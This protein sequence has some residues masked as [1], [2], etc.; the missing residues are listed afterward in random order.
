MKRV[1]VTLASTLLCLGT[2]SAIADS[3][4]E[5]QDGPGWTP[6]ETW[7]CDFRDGKTLEDLQEVTAEWNEFLDDE[8]VDYYFGAIVMPNY[9][10]E[11]MFDAGWLGA[12]KDGNA[13]GSGTD[14]WLGKGGE[15]GEKFNEVCTWKSHTNF[16]STN[17]KPPPGEDEEDD[18]SFV[19]NFS[20]CKIHEGKKFDDLMTNM[21]AW[22]DYA[23]EHGFQ[24]SIWMMFPVY[25]ESNNDYHF[26]MLEGHDNHAALGADYELMGNG[27]HWV[28]RNELMNEVFDCDVPRVYDAMTV[29]DWADEDDG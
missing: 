2:A 3:H 7:T 12:W 29:R 4:A 19:L 1:I 15:V 24:H 11:I 16:A 9:F 20:N 5:Q 8:G 28:K 18:K 21:N 23:T 17:I 22:A 6:V 26:K 27:G 13:M 25:G 14:M 10:G